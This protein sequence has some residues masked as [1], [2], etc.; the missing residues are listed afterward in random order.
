LSI[1]CFNA[2]ALSLIS[3]IF[4]CAE[5]LEEELEDL[6]EEL[7]EEDFE[8]LFFG[9]L[10]TEELD[11]LP[12]D[13]LREELFELPEELE[14]DPAALIF[15]IDFLTSAIVVAIVLFC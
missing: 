9:N 10:L 15:A 5:L 1:F 11:E 6:L 3:A 7:L 8:E 14:E 4:S 2:S 12:E 13:P